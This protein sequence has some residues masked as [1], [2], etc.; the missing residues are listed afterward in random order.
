[1]EVQDRQSHGLSLRKKKRLA[2][3]RGI[4]K[5]QSLQNAE[6]EQEITIRCPTT[7]G[8]PAQSRWIL[9][10][11]RKLDMGVE[12]L[13]FTYVDDSNDWRR[14]TI[15]YNYRTAEPMSLE[16]DLARLASSEDKGLQIYKSIYKNLFEI[17]FFQ[18]TTELELRTIDSRLHIYV[19]EDN[20]ESIQYPS[21]DVV[22]HIVHGGRSPPFE[23]SENKLAL[24]AHFSGFVY[25]VQCNKKYYIRK[26]IPRTDAVNR[27]LH[28][29]RALHA[30]RDSG[31]VVELEAVVLDD[32]KQ[33]VKGVLLSYLE[34]GAVID[35]LADR[36]PWKDRCRRAEQAIRG[37]ADVHA[38]G[39]VHGDFTLS[40]LVVD[41]QGNAKI[42]GFSRR[43]CPVGWE[44]PELIEHT[45]SLY[46]GEK[47]DLFQ[48]GMIL[49]ALAK[50]GDEP[51]RHRPSLKLC[52]PEE[53]PNW[54]RQIARVCLSLQ[55]RDRLCAQRLITML[56][57]RSCRD[58]D[59][60]HSR[61]PLDPH[62]GSHW[63][64]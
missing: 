58:P 4:H 26:D 51:E 30:L 7:L 53:I 5:M 52:F 44:P 54:Y 36:I 63:M 47:S 16:L 45:T 62:G 64:I 3:L 10:F 29:I 19:H 35:L 32:T 37:L 59:L 57:C 17:S 41:K 13:F 31:Y 34:T 8:T 2:D 50:E 9:N 49:W 46:V 27:F 48:L 42:I 14:V 33:L 12:K 61:G 56:P 18:T 20:D 40:N 21:R 6:R 11:A 22:A 28:E 24:D 38:E 55:P 15:A 1:M 39:Y 23:I 43:G 60:S 25:R